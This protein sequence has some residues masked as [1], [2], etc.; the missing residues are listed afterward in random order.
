MES[1]SSREGD[2]HYT[3]GVYCGSD[4]EVE[5]EDKEAVILAL[6]SKHAGLLLPN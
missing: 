6:T 4:Y 3:E 1:G 2:F 5:E